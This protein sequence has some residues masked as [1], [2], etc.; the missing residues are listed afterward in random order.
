MIENRIIERLIA[1]FLADLDHARDLVGLCFA[2]QIRDRDVDHQNFKRS[3]ASRFVDPLEE[4]LRHHPFERFSQG[5]TDLVLLIRRKNVDDPIDRFGRARGMQGSE[6]Q[7]P[8][9]GVV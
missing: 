7:V 9:G 8:G 4:I 6:N 1:L 5:S 2:N 3:D